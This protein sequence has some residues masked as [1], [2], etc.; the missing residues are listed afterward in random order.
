MRFL[1][2]RIDARAAQLFSDGLLPEVQGLL[3]AGYG[4][5]LSPMTGHGYAEAARF[6]MG[7]W[8]L[9]QAIAVTAR[10][11]RQYARRQET[12]FRRDARICWLDAG[13][14]SAAEPE[15][16]GRALSALRLSAG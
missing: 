14:A 3:D 10:R 1:D 11:T 4:R 6:L 2:R 16:V 9:D 8:S 5:D 13:N 12:W 7:E 15:L